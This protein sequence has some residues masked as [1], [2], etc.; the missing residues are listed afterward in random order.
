VDVS[1]AAWFTNP[2]GTVIELQLFD[3]DATGELLE[4][5]VEMERGFTEIE[6]DD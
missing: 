2:D 6:L 1:P 3:Y 5:E 4:L